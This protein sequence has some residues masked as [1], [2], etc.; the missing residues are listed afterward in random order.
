MSRDAA[1]INV[2]IVHSVQAVKYL[3]KYI[4]IGQDRVLMALR[5]GDVDEITNY[6]N[7]RYIS[8][9]EAFWRLY[10]FEITTLHKANTGIIE[11]PLDDL[12]PVGRVTR[13][14]TGNFQIPQSSV[15]PHLYSFFP[16][17]IRLWNNLPQHIKACATTTSLNENLKLQTLRDAY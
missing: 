5:D 10:G 1:H 11:I 6:Q 8:A 15:D 2:E 17:T 16:N 12:T 3:Y 4:T 14:N 13:H 7:A 9:S